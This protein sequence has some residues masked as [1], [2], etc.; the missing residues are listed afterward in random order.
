MLRALCESG[1]EKC[2]YLAISL[3]T[4]QAD[5][6]HEKKY[7]GN[8]M[9]AVLD[10]D[11]PKALKMADSFNWLALIDFV[12]KHPEEVLA[13][14]PQ[15]TFEH[16]IDYLGWIYEGS[17]DLVSQGITPGSNQHQALSFHLRSMRDMTATFLKAAQP[18]FSHLVQYYVE[19]DE[20]VVLDHFERTYYYLDGQLIN[21]KNGLD[22]E[23]RI[24]T[25]LALN[26]S[27]LRFETREIEP[28][29]YLALG[30][31]PNNLQEMEAK[32]ARL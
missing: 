13:P 31:P 32:L 11:F 8:F 24:F 27:R 6:E 18:H 22:T 4:H 20:G 16:L 5:S 26:K 28:K 1:N 2:R 29:H 3:V 17:K 10:G 9:S 14:G 23:E 15:D 30:A 19:D 12:R 21:E 7:A 25:K